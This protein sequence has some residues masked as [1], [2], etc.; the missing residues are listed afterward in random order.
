MKKWEYKVKEVEVSV[1]AL[2]SKIAPLGKDGWELVSVEPL[3]AGHWAVTL[4][5]PL[6]E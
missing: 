5:R 1:G 6:K 3:S 4:K 2:K